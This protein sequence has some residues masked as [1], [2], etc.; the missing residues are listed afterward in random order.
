MLVRQIFLN[1]NEKLPIT[2]ITVGPCRHVPQSMS[3]VTEYME[4]YD[5]KVDADFVKRTA[6]P[7]RQL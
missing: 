7:F 5:Y 6:V 2:G 4:M 1:W 3:A